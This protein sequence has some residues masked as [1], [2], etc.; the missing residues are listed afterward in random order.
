MASEEL[1]AS[2]YRKF[3]CEVW[4]PGRNQ[5]GEVTSTS[6]CTSYQS[7]R[8]NI[9]YLHGTKRLTPHTLNGTAVAV[10]RIIMAILEN[11]QMSDGSVKIPEPLKMYMG[12]DKID[13][14]R[15]SVL[16]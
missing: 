4:Y 14:F 13:T 7:K 2:A 1:G 9:Q 3:D 11:N 5:F 15:S 16:V 6:N 8:L 12:K 10:P